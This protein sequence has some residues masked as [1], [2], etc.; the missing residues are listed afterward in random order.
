VA[1]AGDG[2]QSV[3]QYGKGRPGL[4]QAMRSLHLT[5]GQKAQ[6]RAIRASDRQQNVQL[7]TDFRAKRTEY[8]RLH[9]AND[10]GATAVLEEVKALGARVKV[11]RQQ[12]REAMRSVLTPDQQA[13]LDRLRAE[14]K[15][16]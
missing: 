7:Y 5:A 2:N 10:P 4:R 15:G 16:R 9:D 12:Q 13:E 1:V 6:L 11:A 8:R 3:T 14:R